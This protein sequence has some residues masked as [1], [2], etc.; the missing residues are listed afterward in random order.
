[1]PRDDVSEQPGACSGQAITVTPQ[2]RPVALV[3]VYFVHDRAQRI[4]SVV[5]VCNVIMR[6]VIMRYAIHP[7]EVAHDV[8]D[9]LGTVLYLKLGEDALEVRPDGRQRDAHL[10]SDLFV[11]LAGEELADHLVLS[12]GQVQAVP[13]RL[14]LLF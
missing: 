7:Y 5:I 12:V 6:Y 9:K 2:D 14:P 1:M 10:V 4:N 11:A 3:E 13:D 8:E